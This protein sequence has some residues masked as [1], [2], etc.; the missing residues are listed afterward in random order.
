MISAARATVAILSI[1]L[2]TTACATSGGVD[3]DARDEQ[4]TRVQVENFNSSRI[5]VNA[6][7][8]GADFRLGDVGTTQTE[9][10]ALPRT[11]SGYELQIVVDPIGSTRTYMSRRIQFNP[12]DV[13]DVVVESNL[14]L[15]SVTIR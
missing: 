5:T 7:S 6:V 12:G 11:V 2:L 10:F 8:G 1:A 9:S 4:A 3:W 14:D 15:T 13:I